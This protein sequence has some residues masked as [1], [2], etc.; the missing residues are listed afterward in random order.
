M[1]PSGSSAMIVTASLPAR[2]LPAAAP[3]SL[4]KIVVLERRELAGADH[5]QARGLET[6][7]RQNIERGPALPL[8]L[9]G[10]GRAGDEIGGRAQRLAGR[11]AELQ[12]IVAENHQNAARGGRKRNEADLDGV[13]HRQILQNRGCRWSGT[14]RA[15]LGMFS[16]DCDSQSS[17]ACL[18]HYDLSA[19][20]LPSAGRG[21][22]ATS[23]ELL[24]I[25]RGCHG[26]AILLTD[27]RDGSEKVSRLEQ[28]RRD[29]RGSRFRDWS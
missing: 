7:G 21:W 9:V 10:R 16:S 29:H 17:R 4:M 3:P 13:G 6:L 2:N 14:R 18:G 20:A 15:V 27:Q 5:D 1:A 8:E 23:P 12:R 22:E 25:S 24:T 26:A 11:C 19:P 28:W